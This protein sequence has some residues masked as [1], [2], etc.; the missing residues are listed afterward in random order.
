MIELELG[1][2]RMTQEQLSFEVAA[3]KWF[4][5]EYAEHFFLTGLHLSNRDAEGCNSIAYARST[6][7]S[8][9]EMYSAIVGIEVLG[10]D[11]AFIEF[12]KKAKDLMATVKCTS[13][14]V[15]KL[16]NKYH[17]CTWKIV[18]QEDLDIWA[19]IGTRKDNQLDS[20]CIFFSSSR[21]EAVMHCA[22]RGIETENED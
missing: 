13:R 2:K 20:F 8:E 1:A 18:Y 14:L 9:L 12:L 16:G 15:R 11:E 7:R 5:I 10:N 17:F 22:L 3:R 6:S 19:V 4:I 21:E